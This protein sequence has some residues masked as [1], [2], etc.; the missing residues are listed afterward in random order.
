MPQPQHSIP[1]K[2][3][4]YAGAYQELE[5]NL[6]WREIGLCIDPSDAEHNEK[7]YINT[8]NGLAPL[9]GGSS[10]EPPSDTTKNYA[11]TF[12]ANGSAG[13]WSLLKKDP[14]GS[15]SSQTSALW[16]E[17]GGAKFAAERALKDEQGRSIK[18][19]ITAL[20]SKAN[21]VSMTSGTYTKV[22]V[23]SEGVVTAG[24]DITADDIPDLPASKITSGHIDPSRLE[25]GSIPVAKMEAKK[26]LVLDDDTLYVTET[27][28]QITL[29]ARISNTQLHAVGSAVAKN[30]A[31]TADDITAGYK[32]ILYDFTGMDTNKLYGNVGLFYTWNINYS[33]GTVSTYVSSIGI[34]LA[35]SLDPTSNVLLLSDSAP[36][37]GQH[38]DWNLYPGL[39]YGGNRIRVRVNL[40]A[41]AA[42]GHTISFT[43]R[44]ALAF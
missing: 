25:D 40:T 9:S 17:M 34:Y 43:S 35:S 31:L 37:H 29:S 14:I 33:A 24:T 16:T 20:A 38:K 3:R 21:A 7:C 13:I 39:V 1:S 42:T 6:L 36:A 8:G 41:S 19:A 2:Q 28:T 44:G 27:A 23:N 15:G 18:D 30:V 5:D 10:A 26:Q 12:P 32:D 4:H 22:T 11:Y